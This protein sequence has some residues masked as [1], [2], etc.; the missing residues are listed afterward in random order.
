MEKNI[1]WEGIDVLFWLRIGVT[2]E[3][4]WV[5]NI[6]IP[7]KLGNFLTSLLRRVFAL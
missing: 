3:L 2:G 6:Q 4:L 1:R 5:T 7:Y